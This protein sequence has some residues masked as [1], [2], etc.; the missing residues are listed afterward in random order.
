MKA[1]AA[2]RKCSD[3]ELQFLMAMSSIVFVV[4]SVFLLNLLAL[5]SAKA[6]FGFCIYRDNEVVR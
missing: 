3:K 4:L 6:G 5:I 2:A 1:A